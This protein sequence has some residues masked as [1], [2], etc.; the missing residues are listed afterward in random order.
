M[1][2]NAKLS[3]T[4]TLTLTLIGDDRQC[5]AIAKHLKSRVVELSLQMYGCR[6][7]QKALDRV[8]L[9]LLLTK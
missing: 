3:L 9:I 4:L 5:E 7:L 6:V 8:Y 2:G 1:P